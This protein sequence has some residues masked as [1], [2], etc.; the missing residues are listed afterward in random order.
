MAHIYKKVGFK[1]EI[2]VDNLSSAI[3]AAHSGADRLELSQ[4]LD[5]GGLTP[6]IGFIRLVMINIRTKP[7]F[8]LVRPRAGNFVYNRSDLEIMIGDMNN[9]HYF[10]VDGF[11]TGA[12]TNDGQ[13]DREA[14]GALIKAA[15]GKPVTFHRAFDLTHSEQALTEIVSL[16]FKR[17]LT[18]GRCKTASEGM[19]ALKSLVA[20]AASQIIIMPGKY[21][22]L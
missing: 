22:M 4:A 13:I 6:S 17:I 9:A 2:C 5:L 10:G 12:L 14:C 1:L 20:Q 11:V 16:G 21:I 3:S 18:S 15:R 8:M 7:I 19:P